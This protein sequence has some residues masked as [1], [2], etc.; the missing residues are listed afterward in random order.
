MAL[1]GVLRPR[2]PDHAAGAGGTERRGA[3][4]AWR[5]SSATGAPWT[6]SSGSR[7]ARRRICCSPRARRARWSGAGRRPSGAGRRSRRGRQRP[8]S[9]A[10]SPQR[11]SRSRA[12]RRRSTRSPNRSARS[13]TAATSRRAC[14]GCSTTPRPPLTSRSDAVAADRD[15][16]GRS[17]DR[18]LAAPSPRPLR[19]R[20]SR[21]QPSVGSGSG[22][23]VRGAV[24]SE[25]RVV[26][27]SGSSPNPEPRNP[28]PRTNP[29]PEP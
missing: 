10:R 25:F 23:Q 28:E 6:I 19:H 27:R 9:G 26:Q 7:C 1:V 17:G 24:R 15:S 4:R 20:D 11:W 22:F 2:L 14:N 18:L 21:Q 5:T 29:E 16:G 3:Q 13:S 8:T 12:S